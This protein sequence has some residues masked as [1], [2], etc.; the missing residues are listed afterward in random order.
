MHEMNIGGEAL[1]V[2]DIV[3]MF[4]GEDHDR[5]RV[6]DYGKS[7]LKEAFDTA[8]DLP[9]EDKDYLAG[10]PL[11]GPNVWPYGMPGF[12]EAVTGYYDEAMR[13]GD[14]LFRAF[15]LA[16][17]LDEHAFSHLLAKP[18]SQLRLIHYPAGPATTAAEE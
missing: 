6:G 11:L 15:S 17:G 2:I 18:T 7:D 12:R 5:K 9:V 14:A 4:S 1:P 10:N 8:R 16:L 3:P 13:V